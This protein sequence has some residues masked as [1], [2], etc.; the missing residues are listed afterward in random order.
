M[1]DALKDLKITSE[2]RSLLLETKVKI[3]SIRESD[4][5]FIFHSW[6]TGFRGSDAME[7][8]RKSTY[9]PNQ[10]EV[11]ET[12]LKR[13]D[14]RVACNIEEED[15]VYGYMVF[16]DDLLRDHI[17][18][19]IYVK[20]PFRGLGI[21]QMLFEPLKGR[22]LFV[23]HLPKKEIQYCEECYQ[24]RLKSQYGKKLANKIG[25]TYDPYLIWGDEK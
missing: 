15:H 23:T 25:A 16:E 11:I 17:L 2:K 14:V 8:V 6:L 1:Q 4:E 19:W 10:H 18:H 5:A 3:R 21:G 20:A 12:L 13:S 9:F 24:A 7:G 22:K